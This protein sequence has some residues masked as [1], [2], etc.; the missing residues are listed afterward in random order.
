[1]ER[2]IIYLTFCMLIKVFSTLN[3]VEWVKGILIYFLCPEGCSKKKVTAIRR[4][5]VDIF[6]ILKFTFVFVALRTPSLI[7]TFGVGYLC[8]TNIFTYFYYHVWDVSPGLDVDSKRRRFINLLLSLLFNMICFSYFYKVSLIPIKIGY[9]WGYFVL[10]LLNTFMLGTNII[11]DAGLQSN[12]YQMIFVIQ[13]LMSF[14]FLSI[15]L[16]NTSIGEK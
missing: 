12:T 15:I 1:M 4:L 6:I 5:L 10:S 8:F 9:D 13:G 2:G 11:S 7:F 14:V 16:S 3:A